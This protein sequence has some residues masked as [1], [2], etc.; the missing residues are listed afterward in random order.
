MLFNFIKG[1]N[2][3]I[4]EVRVRTTKNGGKIKAVASILIDDVFAVH[5]IKIIEK[6]NDYLVSMPNRKT[7]DGEYKD[8]AHPINSET[9]DMIADA[10]MKEFKKKL[11]T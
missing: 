3:Q 6:N 8:I 9:R 2:M 5:D 1:E 4:T 7:P 10:I 11:N